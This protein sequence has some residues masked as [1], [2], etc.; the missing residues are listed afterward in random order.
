MSNFQ[1]KVAIVTGAGSGIGKSI[2][3]ALA[4]QGAKVVIVNRSEQNGV[5]TLQEIEAVGGTAIFVQ[6]DISK[7]EDVKKYINETI[8]KF[9]RIDCLV[10]NAGIVGNRE[11]VIHY[12][13]D[14]FSSVLDTNVKGTFYGMK[15]SIQEMLKTGGGSI[16][17]L[18]SLL[19][20]SGCPS[21]SAYSASKYAIIGLTKSTVA[22]FGGMNI[23]VNA[24]CPGFIGT[25][26]GEDSMPE[27]MR[28]YLLNRVPM[29]RL[30]FVDEVTNNALFLLSDEAK[31]VNGTT[32]V[33]DGGLSSS[34]L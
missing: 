10:N 32:H 15:Y 17:N 29:K 28:G 14:V 20:L 4:K 16:V 25:E 34:Y 2:A 3:I 9:G 7:V 1:E 30:G 23:R 19:G 11:A 12:D 18:S 22:E 27:Q 31:Y 33:V 21:M 26:L 13:E 5:N 8:E 6:A 24:L